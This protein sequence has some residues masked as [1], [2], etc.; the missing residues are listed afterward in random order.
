MRSVRR[1]SPLYN[2]A[3]LENNFAAEL[4]LA[5]RA[6]SSLLLGRNKYSMS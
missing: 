1:F 2:G 4:I 6:S 5:V 3:N